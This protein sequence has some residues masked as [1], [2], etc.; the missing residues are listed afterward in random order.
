MEYVIGP[1]EG[2]DFIRM[3]SD[4]KR[5]WWREGL[6]VDEVNRELHGAECFAS[7]RIDD[8]LAA[9]E[10][11]ER[12]P[13]QERQAAEVELQLIEGGYA[14]ALE[15][16][17]ELAGEARQSREGILGEALVAMLVE[18]T[19]VGLLAVPPTATC[20]AVSPSRQARILSSCSR[21]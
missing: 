5:D 1:L 13:L 10:S 19:R 21:T 4:V 16:R 11:L 6:E 2:N 8:S 18:P 20:G 7:C 15:P 3:C 9:L 17:S 14:R 12:P